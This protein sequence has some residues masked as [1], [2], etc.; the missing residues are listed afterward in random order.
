MKN[1][2]LNEVFQNAFLLLRGLQN[3]GLLRSKKTPNLR[4]DAIVLSSK[5][6]HHTCIARNLS[7]LKFREPAVL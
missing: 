4:F 6:C 3:G 7:Y 5:S 2:N 1:I